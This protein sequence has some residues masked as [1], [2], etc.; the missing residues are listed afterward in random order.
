MPC[1]K[2]RRR[3][4][5][6]RRCRSVAGDPA[7][8]LARRQAVG[9]TSPAAERVWRH[10]TEPRAAR[11]AFEH[12]QRPAQQ[13]RRWPIRPARRT[14]PCGAQG[15]DDGSNQGSLHDGR[16][17]IGHQHDQRVL[18]IA[19]IVLRNHAVLD[20]RRQNCSGFDRGRQSILCLR[21][22]LLRSVR[23]RRDAGKVRKADPPGAVVGRLGNRDE[24]LTFIPFTVAAGIPSPPRD[25]SSEASCAVYNGTLG[26]GFRQRFRPTNDT[27]PQVA[28]AA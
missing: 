18:V 21:R 17:G 15:R 19:K 11:L 14:W 23:C 8:L 27:L 6:R 7:S 13:R 28:I 2:R 5:V 9:E 24:F 10:A 20:R 26:S 16:R 25:I 22:D 4:S 12:T 1:V 3:L